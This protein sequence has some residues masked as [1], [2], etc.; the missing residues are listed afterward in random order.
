MEN[1]KLM[2]RAKF[3]RAVIKIL[4]KLQAYHM[5]EKIKR[6]KLCIIPVHKFVKDYK[7]IANELPENPNVP[8]IDDSDEV[9]DNQD[10]SNASG[11]YGDSVDMTNEEDAEMFQDQQPLAGSPEKSRG[12]ESSQKLLEKKATINNN[13]MSPTSN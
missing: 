3:K 5:Y 8:H 4:T 2:A 7:P 13:P 9:T 10:S 1:R 12:G 11:E 6:N